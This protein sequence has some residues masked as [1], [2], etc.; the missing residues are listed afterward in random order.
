MYYD[1][2]Q[3]A[4]IDLKDMAA[5]TSYKICSSYYPLTSPTDTL[6]FGSEINSWDLTEESVSLYTKVLC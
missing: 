5:I 4:N 3:T 2:S 6:N 1:G